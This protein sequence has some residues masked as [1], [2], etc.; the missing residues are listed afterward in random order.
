MAGRYI[1]SKKRFGPCK[2]NK[3][4]PLTIL[5]PPKTNPF[6]PRGLGRF[7]ASLASRQGRAL[8]KPKKNGAKRRVVRCGGSSKRK[9]GVVTPRRE[10]R[11]GGPKGAKEKYVQSMLRCSWVFWVS[12][13]LHLLGCC[14]IPSTLFD[15][16]LVFPFAAP[17]EAQRQVPSSTALI[18]GTSQL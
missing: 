8:R 13:F 2:K 17:S 3:E 1:C 10:R 18:A 14:R 12:I 6:H 4:T 9:M 7:L 11:C 5:E 15:V 16:S